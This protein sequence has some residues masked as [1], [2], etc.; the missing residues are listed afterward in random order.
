MRVAVLVKQIP[1]FEAM[2]LGPDGRLVRDGLELEMNAYCRRAVEPGVSSS[3]RE[4]GGIA[5]P[6]SRSGPPPAEDTLREA[7]AWGLDRDVDIDGVLVTDPAFAGSDT[8]ATARAL[9]AALE[10]E[11]PFD[12]VLVGPQLGRRRH[13][14]GRP[15]ARRA[16]R[17]A[18]RHRRPPPRARRPTA[19]SCAASTTTAG[20]R[21]RLPLPAVLSTAERLIDPCKVEPAGPRR[22]PGRPHPARSPRPTSAPARGGRPRSPTR[23]GRGPGARGPSAG[24]TCSPT[25]RSTSRCE[26][27]V[28]SPRRAR[29]ARPAPG[30]ATEA[31]APFPARATPAGPAVGRPRRARPGAAHPRAA[32]RAPLG[33][34]P[35]PRG[36]VV[37]DRP[38]R[39][40]SRSS[41]GSWG[42][43]DRR[44]RT[45][46]DV[47]EEDVAAVVHRVGARARAVGDPR[48]E[49]RVGTRGRVPR[50][51]PPRRRPH[52]RRGRPRARRRP[53]GRVEAG[54]RR[55][56]R[57]RD[58]RRLSRPDGH[59]PRRD[60]PG[61]STRVPRPRADGDRG[62]A[63]APRRR[64]H[65]LARTRDDDLDVLADA[66]VVV[67]VG[68]GV[69]PERVRRARPAAR[70]RS[71]PSSPRPARSP[72]RAGC[73]APGRSASPAA[74]SRPG[75]TSRS[76]R[77]GSSTTW[78]A[79]AARATVLAVNYATGRA[80]L[81]RRP[82]SASSATGARCV[83]L[84]VDELLAADYVAA[85]ILLGRPVERGEERRGAA[86][87]D[88]ERQPEA[89]SCRAGRP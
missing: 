12:L 40:R 44:A 3:P 56:A 74:A 31:S 68:Q 76:A 6:C 89:R 52:R 88:E 80:R 66:A 17:P 32:R 69:P 67:G 38:G 61:S 8:L 24:V 23:V 45:A 75:S 36:R 4:H 29:R 7:I 47:V 35:T 16:A 55:S 78:S 48:A 79:C 64:V 54:V 14:P 73:P 26:R 62:P 1:K 15:R 59:R 39:P 37:A 43:D 33:S 2:E 65:V 27:A 71:A 9:A 63:S 18:V 28:A 70:D 60:A 5:S 19:R 85:A 30:D 50:P 25:R 87:A 49:H 77:A 82:T 20:C 83:P 53:A 22:G 13:R 42:A 34:R 11:G 46:A 57:R 72:T 86:E 41:L 58:R 51:R 81:R 10:R 84:L 21:P